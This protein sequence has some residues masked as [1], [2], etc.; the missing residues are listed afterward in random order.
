MKGYELSVR[1]A[2][3][4]WG[5]ED[6]AQSTEGAGV[7]G[8]RAVEGEAG[9]HTGDVNSC[10][11]ALTPARQDALV[12]GDGASEEAAGLKAVTWW[13]GPN[14]VCRFLR[15][16]GQDAHG[17]WGHFCLEDGHLQAR[18]GGRRPSVSPGGRPQEN[19]PCLHLCPRPPASRWKQAPVVQATSLW[20]FAAVAPGHQCAGQESVWVG[21]P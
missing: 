3:K 17:G 14:P 9:T 7:L 10:A 11:A 21:F 13:V 6:E 20:R 18:E 4:T 15:R 16:R 19:Q 5:W 8:S 12:F 1:A 2:A